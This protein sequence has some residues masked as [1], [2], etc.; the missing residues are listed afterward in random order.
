MIAPKSAAAGRTTLF[1]HNRSVVTDSFRA[2][3]QTPT[4]PMPDGKLKLMATSISLTPRQWLGVALGA[5]VPG[6]VWLRRGA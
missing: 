2:G 3:W 4:L 1:G 5:T 6:L